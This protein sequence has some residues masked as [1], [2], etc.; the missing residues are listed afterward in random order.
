VVARSEA[1]DPLTTEL[2]RLRGAT[3]HNCRLCRSRLSVRAYDA[4]GDRST[5]D[6]V[7]DYEHSTLTVRQKTAL[8]L[9]DAVITQ[10]ALIDETL[11]GQVRAEFTTAES[12]EIILDVVRNATNKIAVAF[13]ADAPVVTNGTEFFDTDEAGDV[14]ADVDA[15]I[16]RQST[17]H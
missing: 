1:L 5:F 11:I 13:S 9:T 7:D 4:A 2:V 12:S 17:A 10:P 16:V 14:V 6:A 3:V 8:R 15:D